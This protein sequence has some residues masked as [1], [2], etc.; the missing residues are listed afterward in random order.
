LILILTATSALKAAS[1]ADSGAPAT[2]SDPSLQPRFQANCL[3][4]EDMACL[5]KA[6]AQKLA[7]TEAALL[8]AN[9][10]S[11]V[12]EGIQ[13]YRSNEDSGFAGGFRYFGN[14]YFRQA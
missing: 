2:S 3:K 5:P 1:R 6:S 8:F 13:L 10:F 14:S 12:A 7:H 4:T 9:E 11:W